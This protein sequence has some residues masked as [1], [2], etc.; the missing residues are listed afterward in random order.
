[1]HPK[2]CIGGMMIDLDNRCVFKVMD[3]LWSNPTKPIG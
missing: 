2:L 3:M 1:M